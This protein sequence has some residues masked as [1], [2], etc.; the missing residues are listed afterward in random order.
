MSNVDSL[1]YFSL[2][3][4][5]EGINQ[6]F[7]CLFAV[8][9]QHVEMEPGEAW[10]DDIYKLVHTRRF[11]VYVCFLVMVYAY[12]SPLWFMLIFSLNG[13]YICFLFMV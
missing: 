1:P 4:V 12:V 6:L 5:M 2:G 9:L 8:S 3:C 11:Q 10:H 13:L 7:Q